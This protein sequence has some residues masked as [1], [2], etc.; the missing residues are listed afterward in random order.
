[1]RRPDATIRGIFYGC[2]ISLAIWT[3]LM[4]AACVACRVTW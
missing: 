2:L 3:L 1:M 4:L